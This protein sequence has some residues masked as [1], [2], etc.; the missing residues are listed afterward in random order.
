MS[1]TGKI[2][3]YDEITGRG[4]LTDTTYSEKLYKFVQPGYQAGQIVIYTTTNLNPITGHRE[5][6]LIAP[7]LWGGIKRVCGYLHFHTPK[8]YEEISVVS[9]ERVLK[10]SSQYTA[11]DV[12]KFMDKHKELIEDL[13]NGPQYPDIKWVKE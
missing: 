7:K 4:A 2:V 12:D 1:R 6:D 11:L 9:N 8:L 3:C 5:C 10:L 13:Q